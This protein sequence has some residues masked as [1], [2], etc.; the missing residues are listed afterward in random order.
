M[1][2]RSQRYHASQSTEVARANIACPRTVAGY[3]S[4]NAV[5]GA[6]R[7]TKIW[8]DAAAGAELRFGDRR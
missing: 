8:S 3:S 7:T 2:S 5:P 4:P 6:A 1:T